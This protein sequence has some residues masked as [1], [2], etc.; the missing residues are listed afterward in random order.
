MTSQGSAAARFRRALKT[1][2][3]LLVRAAAAE[4]GPLGLDHALA[5]CLVLAEAEP[6]RYPRAAARWAALF[7]LDDATIDVSRLAAARRRARRHL[8]SRARR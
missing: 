4:L 5:V 6:E 8:R 3:G 7:T 1:S 2:N